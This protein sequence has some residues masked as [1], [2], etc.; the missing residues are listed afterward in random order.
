MYT[1]YLNVQIEEKK[2]SL[3][4]H[5]SA[6]IRC[7]V[8]STAFDLGQNTA[9]NMKPRIT[10]QYFPCAGYIYL[11]VNGADINH[12]EQRLCG[13]RA[14]ACTVDISVATLPALLRL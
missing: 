3:H 2:S 6:P 4:F 9:M 7:T 11:S 1:N 5:L 14:S 8:D 12:S 10:V 13:G